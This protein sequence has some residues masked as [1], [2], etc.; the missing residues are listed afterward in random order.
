M[1]TGTGGAAGLTDSSFRSLDL[2]FSLDLCAHHHQDFG[3]N[4]REASVLPEMMECASH[5][6][7]TATCRVCCGNLGSSSQMP[8]EPPQNWLGGLTRTR[9]HEKLG[10]NLVKRPFL[11]IRALKLKFG[12]RKAHDVRNCRWSSQ[13]LNS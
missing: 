1:C 11:K 9:T 12:H 2:Y 6:A 13:N 8:R 10:Q 7:Y 4:S 5:Q 3:G